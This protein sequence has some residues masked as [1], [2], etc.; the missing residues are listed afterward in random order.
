MTPFGRTRARAS[1]SRSRAAKVG[2]GAIGS[3]TARSASNGS[4]IGT[5]P[6]RGIGAPEG[7]AGADQERLGGVD[8]SSD[9]TGHLRHRQVVEVAQGQHGAVLR[10]E[11]GE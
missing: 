9:Q 2:S 1:R 7:A 11:I 3:S 4:A 5:L 10:D 8:S 6:L